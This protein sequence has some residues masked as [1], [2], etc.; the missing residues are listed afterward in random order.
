MKKDFISVTHGI[1]GWF[2]VQ[3]TWD[4]AIEDFIPFTTGFGRYEHKKDAEREAK[5]WA[6]AE[7]LE[8]I[9]CKI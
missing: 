7:E 9:P 1:S 2:A 3:Y 5:D 4:Q 6:L 8:Y